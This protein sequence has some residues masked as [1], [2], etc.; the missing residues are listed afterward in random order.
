MCV[1]KTILINREFLEELVAI[2]VQTVCGIP[3][4]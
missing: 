1:A 4:E 3:R 2:F